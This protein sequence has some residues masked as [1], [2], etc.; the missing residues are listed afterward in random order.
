MNCFLNRELTVESPVG[1]SV[2]SAGPSRPTFRCTPTLPQQTYGAEIMIDLEGTVRGGTVPA[3]VE[4]LTTHERLDQTFNKSFLMT[5]KSF[6]TVDELF[7][8][9]LQRFWIQPPPK[10]NDAKREEWRRLKQHVIQIRVLNIFKSLVLDSDVLEK[11]DLGIFNRI[12]EFITTAEVAR[13]PAAKQ[14]STLIE[15]AR[16]GDI[17]IK[18]VAAGQGVPPSP[19]VPKSKKLKLLDIEPLELARQLTIKD[20]RMYQRIRPMECL[21]RIWEP[22]TD[23]VD[24]ITVFVQTNN[25]ITLWVAESILNKDDSRRRAGIIEQFI[26]VADHCRTLKN[27]SSLVAIMAGLNTP[28]IRRLTRT[29]AQVSPKA[30]AQFDA[31]DAAISSDSGFLTYRRMIDFAVP[32]CV[33]FVGIFLSNL[34]FVVDG[35]PD[36]FPAQGG[37]DGAESTLDLINFRK[38][39]KAAELIQDLKRWQVPFNLHVIP[40]IQAFMEHSLNSVSDTPEASERFEAISLELEPRELA[41]EK[42]ARLLQDSGFM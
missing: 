36:N 1:S 29:W 6:T 4:R 18:M 28:G 35:F 8:L 22:N 25:K 20:S 9:L 38:R 24:N 5:F 15:R 33:P 13:F 21:Q 14:L 26:G 16:Q 23:I 12:Q 17:T 34:Q 32:P 3:L 39:Q 27:F 7:D 10:M 42:M 41:E 2:A 30:M 40:S 11:A 31:C 37:K 19:L